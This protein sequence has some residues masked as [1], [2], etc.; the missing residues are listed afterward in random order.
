MVGP[1]RRGRPGETRSS[2]P[3]RRPAYLDPVSGQRSY[4]GPLSNY[5]SSDVGL[6]P[7]A[8]LRRYRGGVRSFTWDTCTSNYVIAITK[9]GLRFREP[10]GP[11]LDGNGVLEN[12]LLK[13][14]PL[15]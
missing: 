3:R 4:S 15:I 9:H 6:I 2:R 8:E 1:G 5:R 13:R 14:T 10:V 12:D 7:T 11:A